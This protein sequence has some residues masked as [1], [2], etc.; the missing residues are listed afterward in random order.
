MK[1]RLR[2]LAIL[3]RGSLARDDGQRHLSLQ[4]N[5]PARSSLHKHE[6]FGWIR[7]CLLNSRLAAHDGCPSP[8]VGVMLPGTG[9]AVLAEGWGL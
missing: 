4:A 3:G 2:T 6:A 8:R 9:R 5:I 1:R 7:S